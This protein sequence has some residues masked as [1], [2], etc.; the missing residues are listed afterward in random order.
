MFVPRCEGGSIMGCS[1]V[2]QITRRRQVVEGRRVPPSGR[3]LAAAHGTAAE[4]DPLNKELEGPLEALGGVVGDGNRVAGA[5]ADLLQ[6]V[7]GKVLR[8]QLDV[9]KILEDPFRQLLL[10]SI[11]GEVLGLQN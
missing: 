6:E 2:R 7:V 8:P 1:E 4:R 10:L 11:G 9:L 3:C 5:E